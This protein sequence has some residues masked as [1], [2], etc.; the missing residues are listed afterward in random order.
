MISIVKL[1]SREWREYGE[2]AHKIAFSELR[3]KE[4][5][6]ISYALLAVDEEKS[7]GYFTI[8]E[9]DAETA[10]LQFGGSFPGTR[11]TA[12]VFHAYRDGIKWCSDRYKYLKTSIK[13]DNISMLK[14]AMK[15][16]FKIVGIKM[17]NGNVLLEHLLEVDHAA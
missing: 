13:N 1:T 14:L 5:E 6:R 16:G 4:M 9:M 8:I 10:Y 2:N 17:Q 15:V 12:L 11:G 3:P 7:I